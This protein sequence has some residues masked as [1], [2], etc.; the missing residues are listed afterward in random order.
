MCLIMGLL[1]LIKVLEYLIFSSYQTRITKLVNIFMRITMKDAI[2]EF[3]LNK[4]ILMILQNP[5]KS[6][7]HCYYPDRCLN[8]KDYTVNEEGLQDSMSLR[9]SKR[10]VKSNEVQKKKVSLYNLRSLSKIKVFVFCSL[11]F[12]LP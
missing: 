7:L 11:L 8:K 1:T 10:A 4:E 2:N 3:N 12:L 9:K 5:S 6:F